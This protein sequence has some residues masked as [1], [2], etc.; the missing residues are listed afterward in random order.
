MY[1]FFVAVLLVFASSVNALSA[2]NNYT[3]YYGTPNPTYTTD[4]S[5][6]RLNPY[7]SDLILEPFVSI[8]YAFNV[9]SHSSVSGFDTSSLM[10]RMTNG[11]AT[12]IGFMT[13]NTWL[14][15]F[16]FLYTTD[17]SSVA[18]NQYISSVRYNR[19][20]VSTDVGFKM[21]LG[22]RNA[23]IN[24]ILLGGIL[25]NFNDISYGYNSTVVPAGLKT[26]NFDAFL[27]LGGAVEYM[28]SPRSSVTF[29]LKRT[30]VQII[31]SSVNDIWL[32]DAS[33]VLRF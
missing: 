31:S 24:L 1:C 4:P 5:L 6:S 21:P 22:L 33:L 23:A 29:T 14:L 2:Y 3:D 7:S 8:G 16:G 27:T 32:G 17:S 9:T 12:K 15:I 19:Y 11:F 30:V 28:I 18:A 25:G 20:S 13:N 26:G 10:P